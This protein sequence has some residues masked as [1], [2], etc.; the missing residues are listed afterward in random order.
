MC[1]EKEALLSEE[2]PV[3]FTDEL[4]LLE[5]R[6]SDVVLAMGLPESQTE[7]VLRLIGDAL[8]EHHAN[9]LDTVEDFMEANKA[10]DE[11]NED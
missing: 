4:D 5:D 6:L 3:L 7:A 10:L 1:E 11:E 9:L 8:E 2:I